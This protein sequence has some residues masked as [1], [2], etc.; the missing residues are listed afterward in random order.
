M[1]LWL[2]VF[3][4]IVELSSVPSTYV[5]QPLL[6][7]P[8]DSTSSFHVQV[9]TLKGKKKNHC[10]LSAWWLTPLIPTLGAE[11]ADPCELEASI[12]YI[13]SS[14]AAR[15][16]Q[17]LSKKATENYKE[18]AFPCICVILEVIYCV[19]QP[20]QILKIFSWGRGSLG[21]KMLCKLD[22]LN[23]ISGTYDKG[24]SQLPKIVF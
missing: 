16:T 8:G 13:A 2:K 24:E 4:T 23:F 9:Y 5:R 22:N 21:I 14:R 10:F 3:V 6:V 19:S 15:A 12:V 1:A 20:L 7:T 11:A 18:N 17:T